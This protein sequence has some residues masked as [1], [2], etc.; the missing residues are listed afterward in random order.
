MKTTT[1]KTQTAAKVGWGLWVDAGR[2][3]ELVAVYS[4][5]RAAERELKILASGGSG[6]VRY[7]VHY[8]D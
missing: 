1:Q 4:T 7:Y 6:T 2:G 8:I 5:E 3:R